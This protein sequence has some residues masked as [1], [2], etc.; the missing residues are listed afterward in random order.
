MMKKITIIVLLVLVI[1]LG[2]GIL[3][4]NRCADDLELS[5]STL[6]SIN[7]NNYIIGDS[8][9]HKGDRFAWQRQNVLG[10]KLTIV[11][12][13][14]DASV[15]SG[16]TAP[17][18]LLDDRVVFL[19]N[20]RLMQRL[21]GETFDR[22]LA[23]DV[24]SFIALPDWVIYRSEMTLSGTTLYAYDL[25][26]EQSHTIAED[27]EHFYI[28]ED[29]LF[30]LDLDKV[31]M[32]M[33]E[34]G[35]WS[36][37]QQIKAPGGVYNLMPQGDRIVFV[38]GNEL[39]YVDLTTGRTKWVSFREDQHYDSDRLHFICDD[40]ML[41]A[42]FHA[43]KSNGAI[44]TDVDHP[45]NGVWAVDAQTNTPKKLCDETFQRLYLFDGDRLFGERDDVLYEIDVDTGDVTRVS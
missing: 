34:D 25:R 45:S 5:F 20:G 32:R 9:D 2:V 28:Y 23:T 30:A 37:V 43:T 36:E 29:R 27:M 8:V 35:T 15:L 6:D 24:S 40:E 7:Y 38:S 12:S 3:L 1:A 10:R 31:L 14:G 4:F 16:V 19:R 13:E 26:F 42:S 18:Q 11:D 21:N 22:E 44:I 17:F 33:E 41:Y 39:Q